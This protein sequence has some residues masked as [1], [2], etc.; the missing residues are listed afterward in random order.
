MD[1]FATPPEDKFVTFYE[2]INLS[3]PRPV[4]AVLNATFFT[5]SSCMF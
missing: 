5:T 3:F 1:F 2:T 4:L